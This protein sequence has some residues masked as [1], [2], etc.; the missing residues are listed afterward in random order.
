MD[1]IDLNMLRHLEPV[2][3]GCE[4]A[5]GF[6]RHGRRDRPNPTNICQCIPSLKLTK[7]APEHGWLEDEFPFGAKGLFSGYEC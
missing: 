3:L 5:N 2:C 4:T 7:I 6:L 1:F